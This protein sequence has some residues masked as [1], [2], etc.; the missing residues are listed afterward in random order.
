MADGISI[1][2]KGLAELKATFDS[3][4]KK[5]ADRCVAKALMA[6]AEIEQA[7]IVERAVFTTTGGLLPEGALANDIEITRH[8]SKDGNSYITVGPGAYTSF[9]ARLVEYGH[10]LVCGGKSRLLANGKT[11]GPGSQVGTVAAH[12]FIRTGFEASQQAVADA[13]ATTLTTEIEKAAA[14]GGRS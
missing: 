13:I 2:I 11:R 3:L 6:G 8:R 7:A 12:S 14:K 9:V 4:A 5:D 1:D 10:R